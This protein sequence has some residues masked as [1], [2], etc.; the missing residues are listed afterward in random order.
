[1]TDVKHLRELWAQC[2]LTPGEI[3]ERAGIPETIVRQILEGE[4]PDTGYGTLLAIEQVLATGER[5]PFQYDMERR[6]PMMVKEAASVYAYNARQ[7]TRNDLEQLGPGVC[8]ELI[9]GILYL[10]NTPSRM[11]QHLITRLILK[12]GNHIDAKSGRCLVY[13]SPFDVRVFENEETSVQPDVFVVCNRDIL[14]DENCCGAPDWV[15]EIVSRSNSAH[16]YITKLA[17][18]QKAGVREYWIIDPLQK[19]VLVYCFEEEPV[20]REYSFE[21][22]IPCKVLD[23]LTIWI[24]E[25]LENY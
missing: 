18:Y 21:E 22:E 24:Q 1:M 5:L 12:I 14:N 15:M 2:K 8:M 3:G 20:M 13:T 11:H 23:G 16:D 4:M 25:L 7:Y 6:E 10:H 17:V 9:D 19:K